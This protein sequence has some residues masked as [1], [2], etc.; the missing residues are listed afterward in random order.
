[1]W[2]WKDQNIEMLNE[3][4]FKVSDPGPLHAPVLSFRIRRDEHLKIVLETETALDAKSIAEKIPSG[5]L[6]YSTETATIVHKFTDATATL[7]GV[8]TLSVSQQEDCL[9]EIATIHEVTTKLQDVSK[10]A[11]TIEWIANMPSSFMWPDSID[12]VADK[13]TTITVSDLTVTESDERRSGSNA[14]ARL[15]IAGHTLYICVPPRSSKSRAGCIVYTAAPDDE[16]RKKVR[17]ALSFALGVY[18]VETGHTL[19]DP[20]WLIVGATS[21]SPYSLDGRALDLPIMPL[22]WLTDRNYQFDISRQKLQRMVEKLVSAYHTLDLGNLAWAYW[23]ARTAAVHIAPA[24]F[25]ASI[26]ALQRAYVKMNPGK[27]RTKILPDAQWDNLFAALGNTINSAS[28]SEEDK[29]VLTAKI[30]SG[31]NSVPQ[32][33]RLRA[34]SQA[35]D[36]I[37]G[38]DEDAAW[39]RRDQ[40][41]HGLPIPEGKELQAIRDMKLLTGLFHRLFLSISGAANSY[42]DYTSEGIPPRPLKD[43]VPSSATST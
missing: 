32:R 29:T 33:E 1:M 42:I 28:L 24:H 34:I 5:T 40:A 27:I 16:T 21:I 23:H 9:R 4:G 11:Y 39:K 7:T 20:T 15:T 41:A 14:A 31:T 6:R 19:Y 22:T 13:T 38:D 18:L 26:E 3:A 30:R 2:D 12:M 8:Q 17:T 37:I 43:P 36:I 35:L 25:G 10:A